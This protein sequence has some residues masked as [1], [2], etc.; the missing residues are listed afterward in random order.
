MFEA[1]Y[2]KCPNNVI[3]IP[4]DPRSISREIGKEKIVKMPGIRDREIPG[5]QH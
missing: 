3:L 5:M 2:R 4:G 1:K